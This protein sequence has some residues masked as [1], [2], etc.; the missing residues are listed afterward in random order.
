MLAIW[1]NNINKVFDSVSNNDTNLK[2]GK[3]QE[4]EDEEEGNITMRNLW[5]GHR[6]DCIGWWWWRKDPNYKSQTQSI[7]EKSNNDDIKPNE[8]KKQTLT[9]LNLWSR[10]KVV[11]IRLLLLLFYFEP[12]ILTR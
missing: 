10:P 4:D 12:S 11:W 3:C 2:S 5:R 8:F 9:E 7:S 6:Y 1:P